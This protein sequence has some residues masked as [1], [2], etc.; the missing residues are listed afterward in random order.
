MNLQDLF[1]WYLSHQ[2]ELVKQYNGKTLVITDNRVVAHFDQKEQ[3]Y[4]YA[5]SN[6]EPGTFIIQKCTPGADAYTN[7]YYTLRVAFA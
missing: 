1:D 4:D 3:A 2:D 6:L 7:T 5:L